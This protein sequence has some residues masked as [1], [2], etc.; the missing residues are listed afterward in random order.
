MLDVHFY[1]EM[2]SLQV[3]IGKCTAGAFLWLLC[4]KHIKCCRRLVEIL[5][6]EN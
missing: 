4:Q 3:F 5:Q 1:C 6:K 2:L